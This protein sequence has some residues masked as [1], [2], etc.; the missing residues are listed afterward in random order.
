VVQ[1][2]HQ[3]ESTRHLNTAQTASPGG[4][5]PRGYI[6]SL[7]SKAESQFL[8]RSY[9]IRINSK[10]EYEDWKREIQAGVRNAQDAKIQADTSTAVKMQRRARA[11]FNSD[12]FQN[13]FAALIGTRIRARV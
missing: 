3:R 10:G 6:I 8:G 9:P 13:F 11:I 7:F 12:P 2:Q 1:A 5:Q 4:S